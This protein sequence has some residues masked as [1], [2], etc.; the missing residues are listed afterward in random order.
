MSSS[1]DTASLTSMQLSKNFHAVS[2]IFHQGFAQYLANRP[3]VEYVE[4]NE[5][6]K[7]VRAIAPPPQQ[8][9]VRKR[10]MEQFKA[11]SWGLARIFHRENGIHDTYSA[12]GNSG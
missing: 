9:E 2:G 1:F 7:A 11:P 12:D 5:I 8:Q 10:A 4:K 3:D 6:F